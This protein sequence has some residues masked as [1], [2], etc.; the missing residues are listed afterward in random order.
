MEGTVEWVEKGIICFG[1]PWAPRDRTYHGGY[2]NPKKV[3]LPN[4]RQSK[5]K[6]AESKRSPS[7]PL[8]RSQALSTDMSPPLSSPEGEY[9]GQGGTVFPNVGANAGGEL[10][11]PNG[12]PQGSVMVPM[13]PMYTPYGQPPVQYGYGT[14]GPCRPISPRGDGF[15]ASPIRPLG[16]P[17]FPPYDMGATPFGPRQPPMG[18]NPQVPWSP[19]RGYPRGPHPG[20]LPRYSQVVAPRGQLVYYPTEEGAHNGEGQGL[21]SP[22]KSATPEEQQ[23]VISDEAIDP[24]EP[25]DDP[26]VSEEDLQGAPPAKVDDLVVPDNDPPIEPEG[27]VGDNVIPDKTE[28]PLKQE[29]GVGD[30]IIPEEE[31]PEG[32]DQGGMTPDNGDP[33]DPKDPK[34]EIETLRQQLVQAQLEIEKST[35][36]LQKQAAKDNQIDQ[37]RGLVQKQ[38]SEFDS[39]ILKCHTREREQEKEYQQA[40]L[41][42]KKEW[43]QS[44]KKEEAE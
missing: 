28:T 9:Q 22:D 10:I 42:R 15:G 8:E 18:L 37:L 32:H 3:Q 21:I 35:R 29:Q 43:E 7:S 40:S 36:A 20:M 6:S 41:D 14:G 33:I 12:V 38:K 5:A 17:R 25:K 4:D 23:N 31:I 27:N 24:L 1:S 34:V 26:P 16:R 13:T 44:W 2:K 19:P 11:Y 39:E 30:N